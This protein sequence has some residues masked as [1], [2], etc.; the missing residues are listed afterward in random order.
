MLPKETI[1]PAPPEAIDQ[2][3]I[4]VIG[5][6]VLRHSVFPEIENIPPGNLSITDIST[7][8]FLYELHVGDDQ[9]QY[10]ISINLSYEEIGLVDCEWKVA[11]N[12]QVIQTHNITSSNGIDER[13]LI[14]KESFQRNLFENF[15]HFMGGIDTEPAFMDYEHYTLDSLCG[16]HDYFNNIYLVVMT[17][18]KERGLQMP[19]ILSRIPEV[20]KPMK[21]GNIDEV[22]RVL[23]SILVFEAG[24]Y[25]FRCNA[26][27]KKEAQAIKEHTLIEYKRRDTS[28]PFE[29]SFPKADITIVEGSNTYFRPYNILVVEN[30][31]RQY[32]NFTEMV[33]TQARGR[34]KIFRNEANIRSQFA[35]MHGVL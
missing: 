5:L 23:S 8:S 27:M 16:E 15:D 2:L 11:Y 1:Q 13:K 32:G 22:N 20:R 4:D 34:W 25:D 21:A 29:E 26:H 9:H 12:D 17:H 19:P 18:M 30:D 14:T 10:Q 35:G 33:K 28:L 24:N 6:P 7:S 31:I 3:L